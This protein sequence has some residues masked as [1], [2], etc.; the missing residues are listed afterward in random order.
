MEINSC[1][2]CKSKFITFAENPYCSRCIKSVCCRSREEYYC[3]H[4]ES[5]TNMCNKTFGCIEIDGEVICLNHY[6]KKQDSCKVCG[7]KR[8]D[9]N[10]H[11]DYMWYCEGHRPKM[12]KTK[13]TMWLCLKKKLSSDLID[14]ICK[15]IKVSNNR[16]HKGFNR[17][18]KLLKTQE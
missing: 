17:P 6:K 11:D 5:Y 4:T 8:I 10:F 9:S 14:K 1:M 7:M 2:K 13:M 18:E 16:Y 3:K 12:N 15:E